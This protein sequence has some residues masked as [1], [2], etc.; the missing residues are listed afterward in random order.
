[1]S[2]SIC[3]PISGYTN[4]DASEHA[5]RY[6][7]RLDA[8]GA[9]EFWQSIRQAALELSEGDHALDVGCGTGS[10]VLAMAERVGRRGR[11]IGV[12]LSAAMVAEARARAS[13]AG[14]H[15]EYLQASAL[16]LP[17]PDGSFDACR[18]ERILQHLDAPEAALAEL[19]RTARTGARVV[20]VEPD[21]TTLRITGA[22]PAVTARLIEIR[23]AHFRSADVGRRVVRMLR[24]LGASDLRV[25]PAAS[26]TDRFDG[27]SEALRQKY[28]LPALEARAITPSE[29]DRWLKELAG[30]AE[31]GGYRHSVVVYRVSG[32]A[33]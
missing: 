13:A 21:Y 6:I 28:L 24:D 14:S 5:S 16:R 26:S 31:V 18:A 4:V 11:A 32:R 12:D 25:A 3:P 19:T 30:A 2:S 33:A 15:A 29:A 27:Q 9:S 7:R 1:M 17:F 20:I 10:E 23:C 22:D 8:V